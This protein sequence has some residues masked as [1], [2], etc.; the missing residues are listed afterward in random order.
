MSDVSIRAVAFDLD[1][2]LIDSTDAI[3][4]SFIHT[5]TALN[6]PVPAREAIIKP[7]GYVLEEH[8]RRLTDYDT[9]TCVTT[10]REHYRTTMCEK[11]VLM[12]GGKALL[13]GLS[14]AGVRMAFATSKR[15][16]AA[17]IILDH[18][19]VLRYF[20]SRIGPEDI[21]NPKPHPESLHR[22]MEQLNVDREE[23]CFI[24]DTHFDV[25]AAR[26]AKVRCLA[27]TTG[28]AT[29]KEL[30]ELGPEAVFDSLNEIHEY[31]LG[32]PARVD[33]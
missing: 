6:L 2:T 31:L 7:I 32:N 9:E 18:L 8:F 14:A 23:L 3:V 22:V 16:A 33:R 4:D 25:V 26:N 11:T 29:R 5:F 19:E 15:R 13:E 12:P 1:G 28:Y 17:E 30:E 27:V 20:E 24:G 10:Y 21:S